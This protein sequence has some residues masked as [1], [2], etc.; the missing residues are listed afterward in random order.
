MNLS[1]IL[2]GKEI[3][4]RF[5][6]PLEKGGGF[7]WTKNYVVHLWN[8]VTGGG[9]HET[10]E[11]ICTLNSAYGQMARQIYYGKTDIV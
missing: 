10:P 11:S 8:R 3:L 5:F 2:L 7:D 6:F 9:V 1:T 4:E